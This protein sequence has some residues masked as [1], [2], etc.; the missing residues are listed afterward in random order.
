MI[1]NEH[2]HYAGF[3]RRVAASLID[4]VLFV[5][6]VTPLMLYLASIGIVDEWSSG[7]LLDP[8]GQ[9]V[10]DLVIQIAV[11][12]ITVFFW[13][14]FR[15]TPGKLLM[16]CH[17]ISLR[18][19]EAIGWGQALVRYLAYFVSILPLM[20]G[21][22]WVG[23]DRRKQGFHDKIARTVVVIDDES[24]KSLEELSRELQ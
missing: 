20:L 19:G 16:G 18:T 23:W 10:S 5:A 15:G 3:W 7:R 4:T 12:V 14:R 24:G 9:S 22:L 17:V 11:V 6:L 21:I 13:V 1:I 8:Q 2:T